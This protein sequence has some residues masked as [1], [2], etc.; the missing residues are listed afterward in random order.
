MI[1]SVFFDLDGTLADT[2]P[3]LAA[4]LNE[5][6]AEEGRPELTLETIR[7]IVSLGGNMMVQI[8]FG[9]TEEYNGFESLRNR[10]L[11]KYD[12]RAYLK[13]RLY[14]EMDEVLQEIES[15]KITWGII[16]NKLTWL[17][18]PLVR[19][20]KLQDR[21]ACTICGDTTEYQK[22]H[23]APMLEACRITNS[24]PEESLYIGDAK[25]DIDAGRA[26]GM[27]TMIAK[28]GY[29]GPGDDIASWKADAIV[30]SPPDIIDWIKRHQN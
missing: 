3:D 28:Y 23:P 15:R 1:K 7:P 19:Q 6:L 24:L 29:L 26:A 14:P 22:P 4:A 16:T 11:E 13:T 2:A 27:L 5:L 30:E 9:I 25:R 21:T 12:K 8:A 17:T 18:E 20:L 10:F